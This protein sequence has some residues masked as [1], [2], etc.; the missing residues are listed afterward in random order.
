MEAAYFFFINS[1]PRSKS[2]VCAAP[3]TPPR[4]RIHRGFTMPSGADP[5]FPLPTPFDTVP[6]VLVGGPVS[7]EYWR[8]TRPTT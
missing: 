4:M 2:P 1:N 3:V 8:L 7:S 5:F 6:A